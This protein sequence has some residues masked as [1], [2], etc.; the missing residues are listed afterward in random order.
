[1]SCR[2]LVE[3]LD[4]R[5]GLLWLLLLSAVLS[6]CGGEAAAPPTPT[7]SP[8]LTAGKS[9]FVTYCG[10]CHSPNPDTVIVGPSLAGIAIHGAERVDG[11]DARAYV[12]TSILQP[13][14]YLVEGYD[15]LM[16]E[17]LAKKLTGEELDSVV[18]YV[19][20]LE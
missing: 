16:P 6:A 14:D 7:L 2:Q 10:A 12:Y 11:L 15:D 18:A 5:R 20:S 4:S 1:M 19:L 13:S 17:D 3:L 8:E 9:V